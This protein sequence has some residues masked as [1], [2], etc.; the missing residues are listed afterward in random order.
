M[1]APLSW[2]KEY[3]DINIDPH[4]LADLLTFAG[5]EVEAIHYMGMSMPTQNKSHTKITGMEW[6]PEYIVL[7]EI[8]KI[9]AHPN[10]D[11]LV[12]AEVFDGQGIH[13]V[14]TGAPNL[15]LYKE[16]GTVETPI[17]IAY[18]REGATLYDGYSDDHKTTTLSRKTIR[19]LESYSMICSEK[20]LG[21]SE[22]HEG[23]IVFDTNAPKPGTPLVDYI[24]DAIFDISLTPNMSHNTSILGIAREIGALT[25]TKL[26]PPVTDIKIDQSKK[27][28]FEM[29]SIK[30]VDPALNSRFTATLIENITVRP[31][32]YWLQLRLKISGMRPINNVVDV[33]NYVML[34]MGQPLHAFDYDVLSERAKNTPA[35]TTRLAKNKEQLTS[36][37]GVE[38]TLNTSTLLVTDNAGPLSI[39]GIIGGLKSEVTNNTSNVLIEAASWDMINIRKTIVDQQLQTSQAGYRFSRGVSPA[40]A[41]NTNQRAS[42]MLRI[43]GKGSI[44]HNTKDVYPIKH[45]TN[46]INLPIGE[47][48]RSLGI[49]IPTKEAIRI[50]ESLEFHVT[51]EKDSLQIT[52]P[53]HRL[54]VGTKETGIADIIEELARIWG[55]DNIPE[56]QL[57]D[58]SPKQHNNINLEKEELLRDLLVTLGLQEI[59]SYRLS[60]AK[61]EQLVCCEDTGPH[62]TLANPITP[63]RSI[64]RK[65]LMASTLACASENCRHQQRISIFEIGPVYIPKNTTDNNASSDEALPTEVLRLSIVLYGKNEQLSWIN[66]SDKSMDYFVLKGIVDEILNG[67][68]ISDYSIEPD[69][70]PAFQ[71]GATA[72]LLIKEKPIGHFGILNSKSTSKLGLKDHSTLAADF[73]LSAIIEFMPNRHTIKPVSKFP[74]VI[75]DIALIVDENINSNQI[76][77]LIAKTGGSIL[78]NT[79][80]FDVFR[81]EQIGEHKK[82]L[83]YRLTYQSDSKTL[84]DKDA[85][86]LRNKIVKT[87]KKLYGAQIRDS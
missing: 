12:L 26:R 16:T 56:T 38:R 34:E 57:D 79:Q 4:A 24:G 51:K 23:I 67:I 74:P 35:I 84:T 50:L 63:E 86:K 66:N 47:I 69:N 45:T 76:T 65:S 25:N 5:L 8:T 28:T 11:R 27:S 40:L 17:K 32:P 19:G 68:H 14:I 71:T 80:L 18:A 13:P 1:K 52:A 82:S 85:A 58:L 10:A 22:E 15:L 55:F 36:L 72:L 3:I 9:E 60:S 7:A 44:L 48:N 39:A 46:K 41:L 83:G 75:E 64:M 43:M 81:G 42:E 70:H 21:I 78:K 37:D 54:D 59:V 6:D 87:A 30:I 49:Q 62:I 29:P 31:S 53:D 61:L 20:E 77:S 2:L 33:T 73:N